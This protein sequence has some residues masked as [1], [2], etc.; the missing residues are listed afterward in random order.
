MAKPRVF[1]SS[2]FYDLRLARGE[3]EHFIKEMGYEPVLNERGHIPYGKDKALE[4]YCYNEISKVNIVVAIIGGRFGSQSRDSENY[5]VS[6]MELKTA[7]E[8]GK[9]VYI[10]IES[11][12]MSEYHTY[13]KNKDVQG[14]T[15]SHVDDIRVYK[16]IDEI[17]SLSKNNQISSFESMPQLVSYLREQWAG[18]FE[19]FL[20]GEAQVS[21]VDMMNKMEQVT[22]TLEGLTE[23]YRTL[24][25]SPD[26]DDKQ[27][28]M[29]EI[30]IQNHPLFSAMRRVLRVRY[31][32]FFTNQTEMEDWLKNARSARPVKVGWDDGHIVRYELSI[33]KD[34]NYNLDVSLSLFDENKNL[35][36]MLPGDWEDDFLKL[37]KIVA[38]QDLDDEIPF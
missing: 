31:R 13:T 14:I 35:K 28:L 9:Q 37:N 15:Y 1:V 26:S 32:L 27:R 36:P 17:Y 8:Q 7:Q 19:R 12:V 22:S 34:N 20:E 5:S 10:F 30:L 6:N 11:G 3:L 21:L 33:G 18:L 38:N 23:V 24:S 29:D 25:P 16:F 4:K 2:T